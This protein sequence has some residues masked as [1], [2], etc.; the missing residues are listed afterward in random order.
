MYINL[1]DCEG[2]ASPVTHFSLM[3]LYSLP[4][5]GRMNDQ[6]MSKKIIINE[7]ILLEYCVCVDCIVN[8]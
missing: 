7:R 4:D 8:S 1:L 3:Y 2:E 6:H 5:D